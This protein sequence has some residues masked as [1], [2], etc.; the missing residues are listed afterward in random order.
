MDM[1]SPKCIALQLTNLNLK[2]I[3]KMSRKK[4][5]VFPSSIKKEM[6]IY[7]YSLS[8]LCGL[9][10]FWIIR[11]RIY[12]TKTFSF[13]RF[14]WPNFLRSS[15]VLNLIHISFHVFLLHFS[16]LTSWLRMHKICFGNNDEN[17]GLVVVSNYFEEREYDG[18]HVWMRNSNSKQFR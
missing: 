7:L 16:H 13:S 1:T 10:S 5:C 3:I 8:V 9:E 18:F 14:L 4:N 11:W 17:I 2:Y 15:N 12:L 6:C